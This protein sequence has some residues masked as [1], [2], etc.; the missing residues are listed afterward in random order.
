MLACA[1]VLEN[2]F[3]SMELNSTAGML[4]EPCSGCAAIIDGLRSALKKAPE[5]AP[6]LDVR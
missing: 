6:P 4:N 3:G 5:P 2:W 1:W